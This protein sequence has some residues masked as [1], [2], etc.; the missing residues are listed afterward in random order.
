MFDTIYRWETRRYRR[1]DRGW[2]PKDENSFDY[3]YCT[4]DWVMEKTS[5][6]EI[7]WWRNNGA[8]IVCKTDKHGVITFK[9][10]SPDREEMNVET[11]TPINIAQNVKELSYDFI[12]HIS[13]QSILNH[14]TVSNGTKD[15]IRLAYGDEYISE[16]Y[17]MVDIP[18]TLFGEIERPSMLV[19][20][21]AHVCC[22]TVE[23]MEE[24]AANPTID[25]ILVHEMNPGFYVTMSCEPECFDDCAITDNTI[26]TDLF[27]VLEMA[28]SLGAD[29]VL[30]DPDG[31]TM[32]ELPNFDWD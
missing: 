10:T 23:Y 29:R 20:S 2:L 28:H 8:K 12:R 1:E 9:N 25:E 30:I 32:K 17:I 26:P 13:E 16:V 3:K 18:K 4:K 24:Q 19:V 6:T 7:R 5:P 27:K 11:F 22:D 15:I 14:Q 21:T 31:P